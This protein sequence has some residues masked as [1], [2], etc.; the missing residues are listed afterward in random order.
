MTTT[1]LPVNHM[2]KDTTELIK[3]Q[4]YTHLSK[5]SMTKESS[6]KKKTTN[7]K[8]AKGNHAPQRLLQTNIT[9]EQIPTFANL[10]AC[11]A[12]YFQEQVHITNRF[13]RNKSIRRLSRIPSNSSKQGI[14]TSR[15]QKHSHCPG[16]IQRRG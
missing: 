4:L 7:T 3:I 5:C 6:F 8:T 16:K 12:W 13:S 9:M 15:F 11:K 1:W 2:H 14:M 10:G